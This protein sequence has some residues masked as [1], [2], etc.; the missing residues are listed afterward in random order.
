[1]EDRFPEFFLSYEKFEPQKPTTLNRHG[2]LKWYSTQL[3][4]KLL[5]DEFRTQ[6]V[7]VIIGFW[8]YGGDEWN[9]KNRP[10]W[11]KN[12]PELQRIPESSDLEPFVVLKSE[13]ISYA[14]YI[15]SQYKKLQRDFGFDGLFLGDGFS[16]YRSF[17]EPFLYRDKTASATRWQ[18]LYQTIAQ[19]VHESGGLLFAYD[20]MGLSYEEAKLHGADYRLFS[21][22]GLDYL[23]FQSYPQ[24]WGEYWLARY[25][26]MF[27][28]AAAQ[29]NLVSVVDSLKGTPTKILY[30]VELGDSVEGWQADPEKTRLQVQ[31]LDQIVHGRFLVWANDLFAQRE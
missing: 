10:V 28:L 1:M 14:A 22:A 4:L 27:D 26:Q 24:A 9:I 19:A 11:L 25:K 13:G 5:V 29:K 23:V 18:E 20:C 8:N 6:G 17:S 16:G 3:D 21:Q 7:K 2:P 15:A 31:A 30:T 12:H